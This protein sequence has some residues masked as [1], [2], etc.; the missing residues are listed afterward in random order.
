MKAANSTGLGSWQSAFSQAQ[1]FV[2]QLTVDEKF[3][4]VIGTA[5]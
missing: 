4:L 1:S 2:E 3:A 5:G